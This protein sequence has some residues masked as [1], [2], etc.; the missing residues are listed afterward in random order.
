MSLYEHYNGEGKDK[1]NNVEKG[2]KD[3]SFCTEP[4][5]IWVVCKQ[6]SLVIDC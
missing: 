2:Y 6:Q 1:D 4:T 5:V 3:V